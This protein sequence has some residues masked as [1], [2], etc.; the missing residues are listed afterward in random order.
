VQVRK[1][2]LRVNAKFK[3][4]SKELIKCLIM[5][6]KRNIFFSRLIIFIYIKPRQ[7]NRLTFN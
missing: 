2:A 6:L 1:V 7:V 4:L 3:A 5:F